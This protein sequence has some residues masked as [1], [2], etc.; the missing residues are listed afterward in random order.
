LA[1]TKF[2]ALNPKYETKSN[3]PDQVKTKTKKR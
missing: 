1:A 2:E 3:D